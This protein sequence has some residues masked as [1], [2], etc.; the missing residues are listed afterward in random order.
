MIASTPASI[1]RCLTP[2]SSTVQASTAIPHCGSFAPGRRHDPV[3]QGHRGGALCASQPWI[4]RAAV[5]AGRTKAR[6][7][8]ARSPCARQ[9]PPIGGIGEAAGD[10]GSDSRRQTS[11][12]AQ[13]AEKR[14]L[15]EPV[16]ANRF[17][18]WS[19]PGRCFSGQSKAGPRQPGPRPAPAP[20]RASASSRRVVALG[21][22]VRERHRPAAPV[23]ELGQIER[24]TGHELAV[25]ERYDIDLEA[26]GP[27]IERQLEGAQR[28]LGASRGR[29]RWRFERVLARSS[30][31][32]D[33]DHAQSSRSK[34]RRNRGSRRAR[35]RRDP[36]RPVVNAYAEVVQPLRAVE[37]AAAASLDHSVG[38]EN[39]RVA[40]A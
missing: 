2:G 17:D 6:G 4:R 37:L 10:L 31:R 14:P 16:P 34:R 8:R 5:G 1:S 24:V 3:V 11:W 7:R 19:R 30:A 36:W 23:T 29:P 18:Q 32:P 35:H 40:G 12:L 25:A 22:S 15:L 38:V 33:D 21:A 13:R 9:A 39:D 27:C 20:A 28:V 26:V